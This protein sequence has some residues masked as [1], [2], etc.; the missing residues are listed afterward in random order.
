MSSDRPWPNDPP[1]AARPQGCP[2]PHYGVH[3]CLSALV[4]PVILGLIVARWV[5]HGFQQAGLLGEQAIQG[6]RLPH[7]P[8]T[9]RE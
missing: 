1:T 3:L 5:A 8:V 4:P 2:G 7:L 9:I 6:Q